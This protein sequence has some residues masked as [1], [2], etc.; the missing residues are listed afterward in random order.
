MGRLRQWSRPS[1]TSGEGV[2]TA[3]VG[4]TIVATFITALFS[5]PQPAKPT[6]ALVGYASEEAVWFRT[7][8]A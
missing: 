6:E 8:E 3:S 7:V 5:G 4:S 1:T 2:T